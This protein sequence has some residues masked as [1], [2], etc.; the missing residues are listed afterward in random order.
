MQRS[1]DL[2][3]WPGLL[4]L[5]IYLRHVDDGLALAVNLWYPERMKLFPLLTSGPLAAWVLQGES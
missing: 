4:G 3:R 5:R 2:S 1:W